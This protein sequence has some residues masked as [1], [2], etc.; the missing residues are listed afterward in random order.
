MI[1]NFFSKDLDSAR[2]KA[3]PIITSKNFERK[4]PI[5]PI[6]FVVIPKNEPIF[7]AS[8]IV[9]LSII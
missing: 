7:K 6:K 9:C 2:I 8:R 1:F 3:I 5:L 4:V